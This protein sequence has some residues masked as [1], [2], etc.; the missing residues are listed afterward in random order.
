[1]RLQTSL[2][3]LCGSLLTLALAGCDPG[4]RAASGGNAAP[5][6]VTIVANS[7][8]GAAANV[9]ANAAANTPANAGANAPATA[10][11]NT[12]AKT[13]DKQADAAGNKPVGVVMETSKGTIELELYPDKAPITVK[14]FVSYVKKGFYNGTIFHRVIS[15]FMI[16]G[17]GFTPDM[18]EK[19]TDPPI[20]NEGGNGLKNDR[21]TVAMARTP[22]PNSATAQFFI[23]VKNNDFLNRDQAQDGAGY[24]VFG[25][26]TK[27]MEVVDKIKSVPTTEKNRMSDVPT[28]PVTIKSVKLK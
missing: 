27:G 12:P 21:G 24:A 23:N 6:N 10:A 25:K 4:D 16:Q 15:T 9:P 28:D 13:G 3:L 1:M 22:D 2:I 7:P 14:N 5:G 8:A 18:K 20:Q 26:V 19:P 17:G 11:A